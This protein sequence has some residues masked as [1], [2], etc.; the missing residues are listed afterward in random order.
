M[1]VRDASCQTSACDRVGFDLAP[2]N[3]R[4]NPLS[5]RLRTGCL[6]AV[7]IR[8]RPHWNSSNAPR[9]EN[10]QLGAVCILEKPDVYEHGNYVPRWCAGSKLGMGSHTSPRRA[11][12]DLSL[13]H[14]ARGEIPDVSFSAGIR[15]VQEERKEMALAL[16][17]IVNS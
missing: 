5:R 14:E 15:R 8:Q 1:A 3:F 4:C 11:S 2:R 7:H 9:N 10:R 13:R 6:V 16:V 12:F 17:R